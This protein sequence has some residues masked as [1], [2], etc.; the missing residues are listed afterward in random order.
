MTASL[1]TIRGV[2]TLALRYCLM[3]TKV[4]VSGVE[5]AYNWH[6]ELVKLTIV[7]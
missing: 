3:V 6:Q 2:H 4:E 5:L 1:M 7:I